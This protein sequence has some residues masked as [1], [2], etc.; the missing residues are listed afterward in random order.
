MGISLKYMYTNPMVAA[1]GYQA[2]D[3]LLFKNE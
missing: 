3:M 1:T 2:R